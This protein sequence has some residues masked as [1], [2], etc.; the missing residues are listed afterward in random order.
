MILTKSEILAQ[1]QQGNIEI[2]PFSEDLLNP[3]SYNL[4]LSNELL[5]YN[6]DVLDMREKNTTRSIIIPE[7]GYVLQPNELY[8]AK[9][10]E[11]T[12]SRNFV[13]IIEGRSSVARLGL[14]VHIT[15]GFGD[16]GFRGCWTLELKATKSIRV[17]PNI[18]ICQIAFHTV[19]GEV[20]GYS[21]KY[22]G[23]KIQASELYKDF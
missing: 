13:P 22:G 4:R 19:M 7:E 3:N 21:G 23:D 2:S 8:L 17:Y 18:P 1:I 14:F 6:E 12:Y 10:V 16:T 15:A 5:V 11:N 9:T 20:Y